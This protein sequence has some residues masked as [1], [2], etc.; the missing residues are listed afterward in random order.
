MA[1][2]SSNLNE[3]ALKN[4][5]ETFRVLIVTDQKCDPADLSIR[6]LEKY[7]GNILLAELKGAE[8]TQLIKHPA[9]QSV[10]EDGRVQ[11]S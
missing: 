1:K 11:A 7:M 9:V 10:E 4:P 3:K 6:I 8:I 2:I 5:E